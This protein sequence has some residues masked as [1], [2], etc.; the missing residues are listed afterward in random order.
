MRRIFWIFT[1]KPTETAE[2]RRQIDP[3]ERIYAEGK[4]IWIGE[5]IIKNIR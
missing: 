2:H 5:P 3:N 4:K 1:E